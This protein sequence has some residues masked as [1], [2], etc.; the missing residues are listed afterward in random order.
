MSLGADDDVDQFL[1]LARGIDARVVSVSPNHETLED[2][3]VTYA[4]RGLD[5]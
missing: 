4:G 2:V 1:A 3:F 5:A